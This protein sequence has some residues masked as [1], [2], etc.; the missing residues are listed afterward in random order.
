[1]ASIDYVPQELVRVFLSA[2]PEVL[3]EDFNAALD[4]GGRV[5]GEI[6]G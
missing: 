3:G 5:K 2:A 1:M 6:E 4:L